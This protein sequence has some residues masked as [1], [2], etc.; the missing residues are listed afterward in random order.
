VGGRAMVGVSTDEL[1]G[2]AT[3]RHFFDLAAECVGQAR[4]DRRPLGVLMLDIDHF[5]RV[6]DTHGHATGDEVI[7]AVA[8]RIRDA[9]PP[10]SVMGR[11]GGEEFAVLLPGDDDPD[12]AAERARAAVAAE[13]VAARGRRLP[14]TISIGGTVLAGGEEITEAVARADTALYVAKREGRNRVARG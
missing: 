10:T 1:T 4:R 9:L 8:A 2:L 13:P 6:N 7:R 3:R 12:A 14:V 11:Y 5:K